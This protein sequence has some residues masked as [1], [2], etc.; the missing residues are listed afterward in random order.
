MKELENILKLS[1]VFFDESPCTCPSRL[2]L[3]SG[4]LVFRLL[5]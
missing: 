3:C 1:S 5:P 4:L 2:R